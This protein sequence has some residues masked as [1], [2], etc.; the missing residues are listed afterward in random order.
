MSTR[1]IRA[2]TI[3][4]MLL[5]QNLEPNPGP[6]NK[7]NLS[8]VTFN[9]NGLGEPKKLQRLLKKLNPMVENDTIILLQETH[10]LDNEYLGRTLKHKVVSNGYKTNSAGVMILF[11][12]KF[13]LKFEIKDKVGRQIVIAIDD[14]NNKLIIANAYFPNDLKEGINFAQIFYTNILAAQANFDKY[15]VICGGDFNVCLNPNDQLNRKKK[16]YKNEL[17]KAIEGNNKVLKLKDAYR[18][19][20][21]KRGF[22][23]KRG[24]T[25]SRLDYLFVS[26]EL[27][28]S[29][30]SS[31]TDWAFETSD[32]AAVKIDFKIVELPCRGPGIVKVNVKILD[33]QT[34]VK[35]IGEEMLSQ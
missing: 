32:H 20:H 27:V 3:D 9:C 34:T 6:P 35:K 19:I 8:I 18:A 21:P 25:Y 13:N 11:N 16:Q 17:A 4:T 23:W 15:V 7:S 22:S 29:I 10:V 30:V 5:R 2:L 33:N 26:E 31:N 14:G 28:K 24:M 1:T 12:Q